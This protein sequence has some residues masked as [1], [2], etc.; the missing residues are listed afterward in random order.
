MSNEK[1][2]RDMS[3][4]ELLHMLYTRYFKLVYFTAYSVTKDR[5][6]AQDAVQE[7]FL[8]AYCRIDSLKQQGQIHAWLKAVSRNVAIDMYRKQC[9]EMYSYRSLQD[10]CLGE[11]S[12]EGA[13]VDQDFLSG[14][15][16]SLKPINRQVLLLVYK[17]GFTY[18]QLADCQKTSISAVKSRIHRIKRKL[19]GMALHMET[20]VEMP[21]HLLEAK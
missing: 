5:E 14:L 8:K 4:A 17:Y 2:Q 15:L 18:E 13:I 3:N 11:T 20:I 7:T 19:R 1:E 9:R 6:L 10:A 21:A 16:S 12:V